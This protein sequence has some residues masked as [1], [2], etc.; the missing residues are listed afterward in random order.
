M[1]EIVVEDRHFM[2][3]LS[4]EEYIQIRVDVAQRCI[5]LRDWVAEAI[6][7]KLEKIKEEK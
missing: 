3:P 1:N 4:E 5:K 6:R 2:A 7:E